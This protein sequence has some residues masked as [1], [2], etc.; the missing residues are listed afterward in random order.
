[1]KTATDSVNRHGL[2]RAELSA[3]TKREVRQRCGFGC[4]ICGSVIVQ[5]HHFDPPFADATEH[6]AD[7]IT[8]LCGG[9]HDKV[10][11]RLWSDDKVRAANTNPK[12]KQSSARELLDLSAPVYLV[13][14]TMIFVGTGPLICL[15]DDCLLEL[16]F[17]PQGTSLN[18]RFF[19]EQ[20]RPTVVIADNELQFCADA[21]DVEAIG[22]TFVVR[23][24]PNNIVFKAQIHPPHGVY[25]R[26]F[27]VDGHGWRIATDSKGRIKVAHESG[28]GLHFDAD[29]ASIHGGALRLQGNG[30]LELSGGFGGIPYPAARFRKWTAEG[31]IER[32]LW[33]LRFQPAIHVTALR[34]TRKPPPPDAVHGRP[35]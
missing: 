11:R 8:L 21:W 9:C 12:A 15:G 10:T 25:V 7:G 4:V 23:R 35:I 32:L 27:N 20:N 6:R 26:S 2:K 18:A 13:L 14:G 17:T 30:T 16:T 28:S 3:A 31:D 33:E 24:G 5:Y 1:V 19:D 34:D 22:P 29:T